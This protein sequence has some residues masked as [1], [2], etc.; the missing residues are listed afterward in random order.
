MTPLP[1][2]EHQEIVSRLIFVF[3]SVVGVPGLGRV[4]PGVNLAEPTGDWEQNYRCPD[5]AVFL[6]DTV[7]EDCG[8]FWR[9]A[10]DFLVEIASPGD[11]SHDKLG[12][13]EKIGV[14]E[15]LLVNRDPWGL[16]LYRTREREMTLVG[17]SN[18]AS[19]E[20]LA[21]NVLPL[22]F[23]VVSAGPRPKIKVTHLPTGRQ[24]TV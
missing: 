15:L 6:R 1:N 8:T 5:V 21:S 24:W 11:R 18:L 7:A 23:Q 22:S 17:R 20:T 2:N 19:G 16:E 13:Y 14:R 9:G 4:T 3:E 10:A 12:F